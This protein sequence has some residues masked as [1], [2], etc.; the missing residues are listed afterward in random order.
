MSAEPRSSKK[1][2]VD[3]RKL[4][5]ALVLWSAVLAASI[6]GYAMAYGPQ[7]KAAGE[8][9]S[10]ETAVF[11]VEGM[12]CAGCASSISEALRT[13][14]GVVSAEVSFDSGEAVVRYVPSKTTRQRLRELI[15]GQGFTATAKESSKP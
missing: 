11:A 7:L 4:V 8:A 5:I 13:E 1:W 12:H 3:G 6:A 9:A 2:T 10:A 14:T 15:G